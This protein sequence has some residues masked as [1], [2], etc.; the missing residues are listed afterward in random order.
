[1]PARQNYIFTLIPPLNQKNKDCFYIFSLLL[2]AS[3]ETYLDTLITTRLAS[4]AT[5]TRYL[6]TMFTLALKY[7]Y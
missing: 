1:M 4:K 5:T 2:Q 7:K 3:S 6:D